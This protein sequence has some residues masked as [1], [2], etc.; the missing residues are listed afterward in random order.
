MFFLKYRIKKYDRTVL[1]CMNYQ[2]I[3]PE[4]HTIVSPPNTHSQR[5]TCPLQN[6][7][8]VIDQEGKTRASKRELKILAAS[9]KCTKKEKR[10]P[11]NLLML[12]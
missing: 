7:L 10:V 6:R 8:F 9:H 12:V 5:S 3:V 1:N 11:D 2:H 4:L